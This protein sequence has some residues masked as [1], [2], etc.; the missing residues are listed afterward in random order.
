VARI[1]ALAR[2]LKPCP[3]AEI[4]QVPQRLEI[5]DLVLD[6][7]ARTCRR[8][9][10]IIDLTTVEFNL[11]SPFLR[12]SGRLRVEPCLPSGD[13]DSSGA[14]LLWPPATGRRYGRSGSCSVT[15]MELLLWF[16]TM[17]PVLN[18]AACALTKR[19]SSFSQAVKAM[20]VVLKRSLIE[21]RDESSGCNRVLRR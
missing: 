15:T 3:D 21:A 14:R 18:V 16:F 6:E 11:L 17:L 12:C 13:R 19:C 8:N 1:R 10:E 5:D 4:A 20:F 2:W 9:G 7:G